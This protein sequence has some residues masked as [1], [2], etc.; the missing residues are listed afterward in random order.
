MSQGRAALIAEPT[1][2]DGWVGITLVWLARGPGGVDHERNVGA[3]LGDK[4][5]DGRGIV[6]AET[7]QLDEDPEAL[8]LAPRSTCI[9]T[10]CRALPDFLELN[11]WGGGSEIVNG[12]W[13]RQVG[14]YCRKSV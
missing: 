9:P 7:K 12:R 5:F 1:G 2:R 6:A 3:L 10:R 13:E 14:N 8:E 4:V 11:G